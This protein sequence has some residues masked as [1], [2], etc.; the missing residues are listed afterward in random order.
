V[1]YAGIMVDIIVPVFG[2]KYLVKA[3]INSSFIRTF[4]I[5]YIYSFCIKNRLVRTIY[6][7][8]GVD[9]PHEYI[10]SFITS[11]KKEP[12]LTRLY[13]ALNIE[14]SNTNSG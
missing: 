7:N 9:M 8:G 14:H 10:A 2:R 1:L 6:R 11:N 4:C 13:M 3:P 12:E 5:T